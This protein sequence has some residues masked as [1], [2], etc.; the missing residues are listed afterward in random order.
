M[1]QNDILIKLQEEQKPKMHELHLIQ[2]R[3]LYDMI[4]HHQQ[5]QLQII[6]INLPQFIR[7]QLFREKKQTNLNY[8]SYNFSQYKLLKL[9]DFKESWSRIEAQ[10]YKLK[11]R[12][13]QKK[14][15]IGCLNLQNIYQNEVIEQVKSEHRHFKKESLKVNVNKQPLYKEDW[16]IQGQFQNQFSSFNHKSLEDQIMIQKKMNYQNMN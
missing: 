16:N 4:R 9:T 1:N 11:N 2:Q 14:K 15:W 7:S 6:E 8:K 3:E 5:E 13:N 10:Q 12:S